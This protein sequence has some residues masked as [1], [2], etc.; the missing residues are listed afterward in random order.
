MYGT[1]VLKGMALTFK[2]MFR[3]PFT[4]QY[5]EERL[6]TSP[7]YRGIEFVW[8]LDRCTGCDSCAKACPEGCITV[9]T[10]PGDQGQRIVDR[11]EIDLRICLYCGLCVEACPFHAVNMGSN[12]EMANYDVSK[13]YLDKEY[14][15]THFK[16]W[17]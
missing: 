3:K 16:E 1:G 2:H 12:Y 10:H 6:A 17:M 13:L 7:R 14:F 4:V 15:V 5:P 8:S 11:Y 9:A